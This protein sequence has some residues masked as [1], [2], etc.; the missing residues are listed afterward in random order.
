VA[1]DESARVTAGSSSALPVKRASP[2]ATRTEAG[3]IEDGSPHQVAALTR[4]M[5]HGDE[6]AF[7]EFYDAYFDR[8]LR[9]LLV[10]TGGDELATREALQLTLVRVVRHVKPFDEEEKFW[11]WLTVLARSARADE[12]RKQR[13][14]FAFLEK[15]TRHADMENSAGDNGAADEQ[16]RELLEKSLLSLPAEERELIAQKYFLRRSVRE[17]ADGQQATEKAVESKLSR[18]RRKLKEAVFARLKNE[19]T[20]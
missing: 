2:R 8:L 9:Y 10:V 18:I 16:L 12:A 13:R 15:F 1:A 11:S 7:R 6:A 17:I 4:A 19:R 3:Q 14:Y 20:P 5:A